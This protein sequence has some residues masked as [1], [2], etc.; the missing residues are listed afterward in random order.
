M[1]RFEFGEEIPVFP[2][3]GLNKKRAKAQW[4][5]LCFHW[6]YYIH[7]P[8]FVSSGTIISTGENVSEY[9][10]SFEILG[11]KCNSLSAYKYFRYI[12]RGII[13]R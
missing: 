2:L 4:N 13:L 1:Q 10:M 5:D 6:R 8:P 3:E 12:F 7:M 9:R 11:E